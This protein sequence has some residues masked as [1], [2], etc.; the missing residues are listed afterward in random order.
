MRCFALNAPIEKLVSLFTD[1]LNRDRSFSARE[2]SVSLHKKE[3][4]LLQKSKKISL[5][6][7]CNF[8]IQCKTV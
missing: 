8:K 7:F 2:I 5:F 1:Y 4:K 3:A 6:I